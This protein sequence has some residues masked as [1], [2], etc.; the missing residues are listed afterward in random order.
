MNWV[1]RIGALCAVIGGTFVLGYAFRDLAKARI[2]TKDTMSGMVGTVVVDP[3]APSKLFREQYKHIASS[4]HKPVDATTLKYA[5]AAGLMNALGDPH[6]IFMEP[7]AAKE[8]K[9]E[10]SAKFA[11]VGARLAPDPLGAR[12]AVV[13]DD[14]PA[15]RAGLKAGDLIIAVDSNK[16]GGWEV[17][18]IVDRVRGPVKTSVV[19]TV[20]RERVPSS[21][22]IKIQRAQITVPTV[23]SKILPDSRLGYLEIMMFSEPTANQFVRAV[24]KLENEGVNGLIIDLRGNPGGL[25]ESAVDILST[26]VENKRAVM[27]RA[28]HGQEQSVNTTVGARLEWRYPIAVLVNEDSASAAEIMAGVLKDYKLAT[29]VGEHTYGKASVQTIFPLTDGASAKVTIAK[30]FLPSGL[31]ISRKVDD[32][33]VFVSGGIPVDHE[34][35]LQDKPTPI[36]GD[37]KAD[38]QLEKAMQVLSGKGTSVFRKTS[39]PNLSISRVK[40]GSQAVAYEV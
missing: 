26:F 16:V 7:R 29:L 12:V 11:G 33:G 5:G 38:A 18:D 15:S 9:L 13:F 28:K 20:T 8:F 2:P 17:N 34:V 19:L 1:F 6:T 37:P 22:T 39:S 23:T 24:E 10:T 14:G 32:D 36:L 3:V 25:L 21:L 35:E 31:D 30:Y 4:F 40:P 27:I